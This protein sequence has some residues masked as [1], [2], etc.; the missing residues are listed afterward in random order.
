M[1]VPDVIHDWNGP[2]PAGLRPVALHDETLRDGLQS[3]SVRD[4]SLPDKIAVLRLLARCG[5]HSVNVGLPG[6]SPRGLTHVRGLLEAIRDERLPVRATV[7]CRTHAD[8]IQPAIDVAAETGVP[9]EAMMFLGASPIRVYAESWSEDELERRTRAAVRLAASGGLG[10]AF[11]TE[12]TVRSR[13]ETLERL[14][15]AAIEE[16]ATRLVLTDTV[17]HALPRGVR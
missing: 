1:T 16:G 3:P 15:R 6:N 10:L 11:V 5:V 12:D 9:L 17:G 7:A 8:D 13:P 2:P 4:P 14:Y